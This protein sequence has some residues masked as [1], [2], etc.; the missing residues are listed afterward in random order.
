G[1]IIWDQLIVKR[2]LA[3]LLIPINRQISDIQST[4]SEVT[5]RVHEIERQLHE[6]TPV[7]KM[8]RTLEAISKGMS[9]MLAK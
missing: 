4:L 8:G 9:E 1:D 7:L 6:I 5:T 2:T 3:D